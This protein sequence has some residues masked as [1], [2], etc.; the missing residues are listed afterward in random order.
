MNKG[1]KGQVN[2]LSILRD[3][4]YEKELKRKKMIEQMKQHEKKLKQQK[5]EETSKYLKFSKSKENIYFS[6]SN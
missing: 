1:I 5:K 2:I 6:H 3:K 4:I